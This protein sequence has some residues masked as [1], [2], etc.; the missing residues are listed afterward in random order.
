MTMADGSWE[1]MGFAL[2]VASRPTAIYYRPKII[3]N[4]TTK[5]YVLW[6][7]GVPAGDF[8]KGF[9][10]VATS[11]TPQGPYHVRNTKVNTAHPAPGDFALYQDE[12]GVDGFIMYTAVENGHKM[13][14]EQLTP[15][16]L[17]SSKL[18]SG[19]FGNSFVEA[20]AVFIRQHIYYAV[21]GHCCCFCKL[22][23]G[24]VVAELTF[25]K[26]SLTLQG[27]QWCSGLHGGVPVGTLYRA[28]Q[29]WL[30]NRN[31]AALGPLPG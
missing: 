24:V 27:G 4:P 1:F 30:H 17:D 9:Y 10:L 28:R 7:N 26:P 29:H 14:A 2:P 5:L 11:T 21:F 18:N 3:Y 6:V 15:D 13:S 20:P 12:K 31:C 23:L 22:V 25:A 19:F 8:A 16:Y